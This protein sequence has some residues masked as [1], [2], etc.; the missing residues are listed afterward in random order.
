[1][2]KRDITDMRYKRKL[3]DNKLKGVI[4]ATILENHEIKENEIEFYGFCFS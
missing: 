4:L 2:K 3:I 1:M